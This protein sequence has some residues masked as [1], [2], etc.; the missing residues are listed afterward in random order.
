MIPRLP[1]VQAAREPFSL[2]RR[3]NAGG[4]AHICSG[5][6]AT[7]RHAIVRTALAAIVVAEVAAVSPAFALSPAKTLTQFAR[8][9]WQAE[10]GLPQ[11]YI[12][13][14]VQTRDGYLWIGTEEGLVRFDGVRFTVFDRRTTPALTDHNVQALYAAP[15]GTLWIGTRGGGALT[16]RGDRFSRFTAAQGLGNDRILTIAGDREGS[17]WIGTNGGGMSRWKDG[18]FT[19]YT[20][21]EGLTDDRVAFITED[22]S[23]DL[24]IGTLGGGVTRMSAG[25]LT[26]LDHELLRGQSVVAIC[27]VKDGTVWIGTDHGVVRA[28]HGQVERYAPAAAIQ[29]QR[30]LSL[31]ED[32]D[33]TIWVGTN[34]GGLGAV[35][36]G[37]FDLLRSPN[38]SSNVVVT[39]AEDREGSL[40][41]GTGGGGLNRLRDTSF[42]AITPREGLPHDVALATFEDRE[43]VLWVGTYGGGVVT[44]RDGVVV[45]FAV[46]ATLSHSIVYSVAEDSKGTLWFATG[47]AGVFRVDRASR[48]VDRFGTSN[49]LPHNGAYVILPI[50]DDVWIGTRGGLSRIRNRDV[51]TYTAR[52]GLTNE[53]VRA[54]AAGPDG[55]VWVGTNGGGVLF[56]KDDTFSM[57]IKTSGLASFVRAIV[58]DRAGVLWIGTGGGGL[59]RVTSNGSGSLETVAL[60]TRDGL[61][62]DVVFQVLED[63]AGNLWLSS[64]KGIARVTRPSLD[65]RVTRRNQPLA[66]TTFGRADGMPSTECNGGF[67]PAGWSGR[68]GRL[69]FP[70]VRGVVSVDPVHLLVNGLPP[71]VVIEEALVDK[72]PVDLR[73]DGNFPLGDGGLEFR[74]TAL[75][76]VDPTRVRFRYQLEG[77]DRDWIDAGNRR[78]AFYTNMPSGRYTFR[79]RASNNDGVWSTSGAAYAFAL[80]PR[81]YQTGWFYGACIVALVGTLAAAYRFRG[82]RAEARESELLRLVEERTSQLQ[83]ANDHLQRLSYN[84]ALTNIPNR[85]HFEEILEMEW[86]RAF[87]ANSSIALL[88]MDIDHFKM[89]NDTFGHRAGDV[90]LIRV[91]A[92]LDESVQRAG[93]LVARYGGE[94]FAAVLAGTTAAGALEVGERLRAAVEAL[95]IELTDRRRVTI[96]VGIAAG[97]PG[98][99]A[100][101]E[102]LLGAADQALYEAKREGRNR[103]RASGV[104]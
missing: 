28:A 99:V 4:F 1:L 59:L 70:T 100:S 47:N 90:C 13:A 35:R 77:F 57:P 54:L 39:L 8:D 22:Q 92:A 31:L 49:G 44:V 27:P 42:T 65:A 67:Q 14:V 15:D 89:Y 51:K 26:A 32:R 58:R 48:R 25:K 10:Q 80:A 97:V 93:D 12:N 95:G 103:V 75:S 88:M 19:T 83:Q 82:N 94:E 52:D 73:L 16:L 50:G 40:W 101:S 62:D 85:R 36:R 7:G 45:P 11:N 43:G 37:G 102:A 38:L 71:P 53:Y 69:W 17:I 60:T 64:N 30:V 98:Q 96:S 68:D 76:L 63:R 79:V 72:R 74:Y 33:R 81:F 3:G 9:V 23:G 86:R 24:W 56:L 87:R 55:G 78:V 2:W 5:L 66:V 34:D 84:D 21:R 91:A 20:V 46:D 29:S 61:A 104:I 6:G 18:A 41:V